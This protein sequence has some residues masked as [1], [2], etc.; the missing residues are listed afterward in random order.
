VA[1]KGQRMDLQKSSCTILV[2][3]D[4]GAT[5]Y[6]IRRVLEESGFV[7]L[8]AGT[9]DEAIRVAEKHLES[10]DLIVC[11]VV[12]PQTIGTLVIKRLIALKPEMKI[13]FISG[14]T[15]VS[16]YGLTNTNYLKKPFTGPEL[17]QTVNEVLGEQGNC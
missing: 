7:V 2:I 10:I 15:D 13:I 17:V 6:F 3:E 8:E 16:T 4:D 5:R 9:G 11:D 14:L 1:T 12:L